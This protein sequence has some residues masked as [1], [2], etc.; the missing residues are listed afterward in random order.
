MIKE[1]DR[2]SEQ[3]WK[4]WEKAIVVKVRLSRLNAEQVEFTVSEGA[5]W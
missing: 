4:R 3:D 2:Y 5:L 1:A